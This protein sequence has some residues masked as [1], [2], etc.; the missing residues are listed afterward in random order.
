MKRL[1]SLFAMLLCAAAVSAQDYGQDMTIKI[2]DNA[3]APHSNEITEAETS[4]NNVIVNTLK[5]KTKCK[6]VIN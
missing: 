6:I 3:T 2:W 5:R 4:N 1:L